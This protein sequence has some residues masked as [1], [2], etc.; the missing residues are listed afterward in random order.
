MGLI[1]YISS[2]LC[3]FRNSNRYNITKAQYQE[4]VL[5]K[6]K[7]R[8]K[9]IAASRNSGKAVGLPLE[10]DWL[11][12]VV[13]LLG[14][15]VTSLL[16]WSSSND[17]AL[18]YC[19]ASSGCDVIQNSRW[20]SFLGVPLAAWGA[21]TYLVL[22]LGSVGL[23]DKATSAKITA[24]V[25]AAG[26][27]ISCYLT[28]IGYFYLGAFC[29]YCL[30]SLVLIAF[31]F[32]VSLKRKGQ[33]R[34]QQLYFGGA[35]SLL[36]IILMHSANTDTSIFGGE[37]D[38][39]LA[40]LATHLSEKGFK[41]YGASWC[42]HCQEQK[43]LFGKASER[44]PYVECSKYGPNGPSTTE[45]QLQD[46]RNYPTWIINGRRFE[47]ILTIDRLKGLSGFK[48]PKLSR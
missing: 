23:L 44:L 7:T 10:I 28:A 38:P 4:I 41:F 32:I 9:S 2:L 42:N 22:T 3:A 46:V 33:H 48:S 26:F 40:A 36:I 18:P 31:S 21:L 25:S 30:A 11:I 35:A 45:C 37:E 27:F 8:K 12:L 24:F 1:F 20:S 6:R 15:G 13:G 43:E 16:L 14:L 29:Q 47:Y 39:E 34:R 5:N 17:M 19:S